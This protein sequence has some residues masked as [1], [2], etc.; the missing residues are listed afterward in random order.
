MMFRSGRTQEQVFG[1]AIV[2][3]GRVY[4]TPKQ[5]DLLQQIYVLNR[6]DWNDGDKARA[7]VNAIGL[8]EAAF[9]RAKVTG[10]EV[11]VDYELRDRA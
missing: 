8:S 3:N 10:L 7:A 5:F 11:V 2:E 1:G 9:E 6:F 4:V